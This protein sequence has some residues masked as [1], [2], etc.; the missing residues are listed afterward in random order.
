MPKGRDPV[1]RL[2]A[3]DGMQLLT[4]KEAAAYL[5]PGFDPKWVKA[6]AND[7]KTINVIRLTK[8][9]VVIRKSELD[10]LIAEREG[11]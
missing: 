2:V 4:Y 3:E 11:R 1:T 7:F 6:Q 10:R 5:G 8:T 9:K